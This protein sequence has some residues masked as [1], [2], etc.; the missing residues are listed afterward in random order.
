M[1]RLLAQ[2][3]VFITGNLTEANRRLGLDYETVRGL[4][5]DIVYCQVT[6]FGA[7]GPYSSIP[8]HGEMMI[9]LGGS[10]PSLHVDQHGFV[11]RDTGASIPPSNAGVVFGPLYGAYGIAAGL[12]RRRLNGEGCYIDI[13]CAEAIMAAGWLDSVRMLNPEKID[14]TGPGGHGEGWTTDSWD[15]AAKHQY[16]ETSDRKVVLFAAIEPKLWDRFCAGVEREDLAGQHDRDLAVD[17]QGSE[18]L[19]LELQA[20]FGSKTLTEWTEFAVREHVPITPVLQF[21]DLPTDPHVKA[22]HIIVQDDHPVVGPFLTPGNP[23]VVAD[24]TYHHR[25]A[26]DQGQHTREILG[27]LGYDDLEVDALRTGGA[28]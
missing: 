26:P 25:S 1:S 23:I 9:A 19:R 11:R 6:G 27:E 14:P 4:K 21:G 24:T 18:D 10:G 13:S 15:R 2:A 22:R 3:D 17:T 8:T 16:Y 12:A 20:I 5:P 28:I 7:T